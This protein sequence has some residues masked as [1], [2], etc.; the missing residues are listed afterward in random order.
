M[1]GTDCEAGSGD[2]DI[3]ERETGGFICACSHP[4]YLLHYV[5]SQSGVHGLALPVI[6]LSLPISVTI[7][8][9]ITHRHV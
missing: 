4:A 1:K 6:K 2:S 5:Q 9:N 8:K 7:T 3:L